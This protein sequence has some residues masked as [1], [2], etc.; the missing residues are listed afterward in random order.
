MQYSYRQLA[1]Q[2]VLEIKSARYA[3]GERL[4]SVRQLALT[5]RVSV[6]TVM[7]CY[8]YLEQHGLIEAR[9][10]SGMYVADWKQALLNRKLSQSD[11]R[12]ITSANSAASSISAPAIEYE[13]LVSLEYRMAQLYS[14]TAQ[15]LELGLHLASAV[16][17]WYPVEALAKIGQKQLRNHH[18]YIGAYPTGSGCLNLKQL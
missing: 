10:K 16:S 17:E 11:A 15:T 8:R 6:S 7:R 3:P 5:H 2:L 1:E 18:S 14:L 4:P 9:N 13:K 12:S